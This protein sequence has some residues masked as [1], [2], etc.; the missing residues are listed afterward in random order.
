MRPQDQRSVA[1]HP[2]AVVATQ[3]YVVESAEAEPSGAKIN[4]SS[5]VDAGRLSLESG[6][7]ADA[8]RQKVRRAPAVMLPT[9][10]RLPG[11]ACVRGGD[12]AR[13]KVGCRLADDNSRAG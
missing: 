4:Y 6:D 5:T 13:R 11:F 3:L 8:G 10:D 7:H 1:N 12:H 9:I 2:T